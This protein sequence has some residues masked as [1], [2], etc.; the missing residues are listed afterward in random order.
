MEHVIDKGETIT[1][2][3]LADKMNELYN[4]PEKISP[5]V[6]CCT[7]DISVWLI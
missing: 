5:K 1:H 3:A 2:A 6:S 7:V 4:T